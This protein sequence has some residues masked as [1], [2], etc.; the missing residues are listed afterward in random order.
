MRVYRGAGCGSDHHL[1][2]ENILINYWR[3]SNLTDPGQTAVES[4]N[5]RNYNLESLKQE[6]TQFLYKFGLE[7]KLRIVVKANHAAKE[8]F[9]KINSCIHEASKEVMRHIEI[10]AKQNTEWRSQ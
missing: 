5:N 3:I 7:K 2:I 6:I 1:I 9:G 4:L 10:D 8:L